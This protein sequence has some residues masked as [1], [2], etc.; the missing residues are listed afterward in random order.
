MLPGGLASFIT[1]LFDDSK[2]TKFVKA[3]RNEQ[4]GDLATLS[5]AAA[6]T[7]ARRMAQANRQPGIK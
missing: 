1:T 7:M 3:R 5:G 2:Q 4:D 6:Y